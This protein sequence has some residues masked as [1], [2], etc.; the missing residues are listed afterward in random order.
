MLMTNTAVK[1]GNYGYGSALAVVTFFILLIF[2]A[3]YLK[4][5]G[6]GKQEA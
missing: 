1:T 5:T 3:A 2:A 6:F 4:L